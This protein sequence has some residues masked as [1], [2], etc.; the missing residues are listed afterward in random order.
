MASAQSWYAEGATRPTDGRLTRQ[1]PD[2]P[3]G[4]KSGNLRRLSGVLIL[5]GCMGKSAMKYELNIP[6]ISDD[7]IPLCLVADAMARVAATA[8]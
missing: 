3:D 4:E 5:K 2:Y 1:A 8:F 7:V 6:A